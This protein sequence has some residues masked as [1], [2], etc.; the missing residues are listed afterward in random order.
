VS[1]SHG[2]PNSIP[3]LDLVTPHLDLEQE[4][5]EVFRKAL[6]TAGFI[7]GPMVGILRKHSRRSAMS[8][9]PSPLAAAP[10]HY[11]SRSWPTE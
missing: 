2:T 9:I 7:G 4:L 8:A 1:V 5:T 3:F 10:T 11:G 6:R